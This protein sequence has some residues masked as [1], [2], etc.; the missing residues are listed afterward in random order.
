MGALLKKGNYSRRKR[1]IIEIYIGKFCFL[2]D[3]DRMESADRPRR[4]VKH[5]NLERKKI[6][7]ETKRETIETRADAEGNSIIFFRLSHDLIPHFS[8]PNPARA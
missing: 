8:R 6:R 1:K 5:I 2:I 3:P 7:N 4:L